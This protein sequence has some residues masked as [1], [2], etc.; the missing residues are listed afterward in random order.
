MSTSIKDYV[1]KHLSTFED[2]LSQLVGQMSISEGARGVT[3]CAEILA[4]LVGRAGFQKVGSVPTGCLPGVWGFLD[5]GKPETLAV[6]AMFDGPPISDP[7]KR[8][9]HQ[10]VL[11]PFGP[12]PRV[13]FGKGIGTKGP[14]M[15]F[16]WALK[17][18]QETGGEL[19]FN[20]ACVLEGEEW[21]GSTHYGDL[22]R[23]HRDKMRGCI[24]A[25]S[26]AAGQSGGGGVSIGLGSKGCAYFELISSGAHWGKGPVTAQ[27]HSSAQNVVHSPVWR[28]VEALNL[29][30]EPGSAGLE[31][32][33]PGFY[34]GIRL[35][36]GRE[37]KL[38]QAIV[39]SHG[40][41]DWREVV[42][43]VRG[44]GRITEI[45]KGLEGEELLQRVLYYPTLNINGLRAGYTGPDS[46]L[47]SL[48]GEAI[49]RLDLR[50][51]RDQRGKTLMAAIRRHLDDA[52]YDDI[53]IL[54]K[55]THDWAT[56]SLDD[57]IV[58]G[59]LAMYEERGLPVTIWPFQPA[60]APLGEFCHQ[61]DVPALGGVGIGTTGK[62]GPD[63]F[64]VIEGNAA[65]AGIPEAAQFF[66]DYLAEV[67]RVRSQAVR[68][69]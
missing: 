16:L 12:Y 37:R 66:A 5:A 68:S 60:G 29:L 31:V 1:S 62:D 11:E 10:P 47:F 56:A 20:I 44:R 45:Y 39:A 34:D 49:A 40:D 32:I 51:G 59:A 14:L 17:A 64:M 42:P 53:Q 24:G 6:Y 13:M 65:I 43:G 3:E 7:W 57:A 9:P 33:V 22:V 28:L 52:G 35:P 63:E 54:D 23:Q 46:S 27:V 18:L 36:E 41:V 21:I 25:I 4:G 8:D 15:T 38:L 2:E 67:S 69:A 30:T 50:F 61:L 55:G 26:P 19:P 58:Q 48:P